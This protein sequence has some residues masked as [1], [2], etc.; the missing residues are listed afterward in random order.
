MIKKFGGYEKAETFKEHEKLPIGG[1]ILKILNAE[2]KS[3]TW[4]DVLVLSFDID[5]GDYKGFYKSNYASQNSE[6]KKWK[7]NINIVVPKEDGS[8]KDN[9]TLRAFKTTI[10]AIEDSNNGYHWD[11]D[12]NKFKGK[13][14]GGL[15][16]NKEW[17]YNGNTGFFTECCRLISV[18]AIKN[19]KFKVPEDKLLSGKSNN[20]GNPTNM[21]DSTDSEIPF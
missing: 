3:Y 21:N 10:T 15:F 16:R 20:S 9:I 19:D 2:E 4:G 7:G 17:E 8:E 5:E 12:E 6:E 13:L 11:W 18:D 1:Y 14:I